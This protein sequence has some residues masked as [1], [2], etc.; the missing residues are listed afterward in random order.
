MVLRVIT[1]T[2]II[3]DIKTNFAILSEINLL[4]AGVV[5]GCRVRLHL[6]GFDYVWL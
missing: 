1:N 2:C 3:Y 5:A 4:R 6:V